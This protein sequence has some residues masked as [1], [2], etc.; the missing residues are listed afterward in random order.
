MATQRCN[1]MRVWGGG[2]SAM[3]AFVSSQAPRCCARLLSRGASREALTR[4]MIMAPV[5]ML[6]AGV[7]PSSLHK[8]RVGLS[9]RCLVVPHPCGYP[10]SSPIG[11]VDIA[12]VTASH[13]TGHKVWPHHNT[14]GLLLTQPFSPTTAT[15]GGGDRGSGQDGGGR[16]Q[17][18]EAA[19]GDADAGGPA[20]HNRCVGAR[21]GPLACR[22]GPSARACSTPPS[23]AP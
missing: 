1:V 3:P 18:A 4:R 11:A 20:D 13:S 22:R 23:R 10:F 21:G 16:R 6:C 17:G 14:T 2:A 8:S 5:L 7:D 12:G 9:G 19:T 15:S